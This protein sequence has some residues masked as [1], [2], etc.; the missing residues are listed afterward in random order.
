M[1]S[2]TIMLTAILLGS[3]VT[4]KVDVFDRK[5]ALENQMLGTFDQ[6]SKDMQLVASVRGTDAEKKQIHMSETRRRAV[7]AMQSREFNR[8]DIDDLEAKGIIGENNRGFLS[9]LEENAQGTDQ[10][11]MA[12][13]KRL[14]KEENRDRQVILESVVTLSE[15]L[16]KADLPDVRRTYH[17]MILENL[18]PGVYVQDDDGKWM[19]KQ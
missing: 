14:V 13:A 2:L 3:C 17:Q 8:D 7:A 9:I 5:T 18:K 16:T 11:T 19:K 10:K 4:A 12:L 15:N 6:L 1:R